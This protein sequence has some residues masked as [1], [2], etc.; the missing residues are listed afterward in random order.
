VKIGI[1][2]RPVMEY[3]HLRYFIVPAQPY[4]EYGV[5]GC[6]TLIL[7]LITTVGGG[8]LRDAL[9]G[10]SHASFPQPSLIAI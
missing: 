3:R 7:T 10:G 9:M 2:I 1:R 5:V 6:G 8:S 4:A